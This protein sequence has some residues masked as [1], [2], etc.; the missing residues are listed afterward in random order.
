[1]LN[2]TGSW[3]ERPKI[4]IPGCNSYKKPDFSNLKVAALTF[5]FMIPL[6]LR[7]SGDFRMS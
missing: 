6:I 4:K 2:I 1:L 5:K 3:V 7:T